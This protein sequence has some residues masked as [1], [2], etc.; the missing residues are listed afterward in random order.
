MTYIILLQNHSHGPMRLDR[1]ERSRLSGERF[2]LLNKAIR[3]VV[4][5]C[6]HL[7]IFSESF[8]VIFERSP[9][10]IIVNNQALICFFDK[11]TFRRRE[12]RWIETLGTFGIFHITLKC[13]ITHVFG[14][15]LSR[16]PNKKAV[17]NDGKVLYVDFSKVI[18]G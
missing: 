2:L 10:E 16:I 1:I 18:G 4:E 12:A 17:I 3:L 5:N 15:A 6:W 11:P 13:E 9:T 7:F 14:I 8:V